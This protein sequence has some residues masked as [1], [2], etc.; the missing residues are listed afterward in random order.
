[1]HVAED[2]PEHQNSDPVP[3]VL[4]EEHRVALDLI[5][6]ETRSADDL[7]ASAAGPPQFEMWMR[8]PPVDA[9]LA[10]ALTAYATDLALIGTALRPLEGFNQCGN[11][12]AFT[13]AVTSHT[14][15]FHRPFRTDQ[16]LLLRQHSPVLA[17]GRCFGRG[18]VRCD[19]GTLVAATPRRHSCV[20]TS[21]GRAQGNSFAYR[22]IIPI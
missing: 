21:D 20:S 9:D 7:D 4:G 3:P 14:L 19:D 8:T 5:P 13:S 22:T 6:W 18:D 2:G 17:H 10:P 12:T 1:M 16:W 15:W 11:G